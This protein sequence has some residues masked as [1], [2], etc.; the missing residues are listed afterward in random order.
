MT[1]IAAYNGLVLFVSEGSGGFYERVERCMTRAGAVVT[2]ADKMPSQMATTGG[3]QVIAVVSVSAL[4]HE[5]GWYGLIDV[6]VIWVG[7]E[8]HDSQTMDP[9]GGSRLLPADFTDGELRAMVGSVVAGSSPNELP[10]MAGGIQVVAKSESMVSLLDEVMAFA[11]SDHNVLV[12]GETGVGKELIA[13]LLHQAHSRYSQGPFVAVN[14]G[15]IPDG[16]FESLFFGHTKGSFTGAVQS[17]K[18]YLEQA[19][20]GTLFMDEVGDLPLF[21]QVKLLRVLESGMMTRVGSEVPVQLDFRLVAATNRN[22]RELVKAGT[23]RSDLFYRLAVIEFNVPNLEQRGASDKVAIFRMMIGRI[24]IPK[25]S[26]A[27]L[28]VP[29]WLIDRVATMRFPGNVRQLRNL[30]ERVGVIY[31]QTGTWDFRLISS[32]LE[33]VQDMDAPVAGPAASRRASSADER[34]RIIAELEKNGWQR[35]KTAEQLGMSRKSL[36]EKMRKFGIEDEEVG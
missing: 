22:L 19:N 9:L 23:F 32:A 7:N 4:N 10:T 28:D 33:M 26:S 12:H 31:Q 35:Q 2:R 16:L 1:G 8:R 14:C 3:R 13:G 20:G 11:D 36:W 21:Q 17:H 6:P 18:G 30:A 29:A 24:V 25:N 34:A 27:S 5:R 15:A